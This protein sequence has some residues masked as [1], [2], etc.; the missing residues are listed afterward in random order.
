MA[1]KKSI[2]HRRST[3]PTAVLSS[4]FRIIHCKIWDRGIVLGITQYLFAGIINLLAS[5]YMEERRKYGTVEKKNVTIRRI[6]M[7]WLHMEILIFFNAR[8]LFCQDIGA[9]RVSHHDLHHFWKWSYRR[10]WLG[11]SYI[12]WPRGSNVPFLVD[13]I[14][15]T[16]CVM[17]R[18][19]DVHKAWSRKFGE[20]KILIQKEME[21]WKPQTLENEFFVLKIVR[22]EWQTIEMPARIVSRDTRKED[23]S[24]TTVTNMKGFKW[25]YVMN[26]EG[27]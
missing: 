18:A 23:C 9:F 2:E 5:K 10:V 21:V 26:N 8:H 16:L 17:H 1:I 11:A 25:L 24:L 3:F 15:R 6:P 27:A 19:S 12:F 13:P 7:L 4:L 14:W 22:R 20:E